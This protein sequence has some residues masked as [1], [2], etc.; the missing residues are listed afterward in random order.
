M[1]KKFSIKQFT[2]KRP[3]SWS[4]LSQWEYSKEDW[5][6]KYI[7]EEK[8]KENPEMVFGKRLAK[9]IEDGKPLAPVTMLPAREHKFEV[10]FNGIKLIGF[11]DGFDPLEKRKLA[12][13][14]SGF[15]EWNQKRVDEHGQLDFYLLCNY[16]TS[17][18]R[19]EEVDCFL[20]WIPTVKIPQENGDFKGD[21]YRI[22]FKQPI[23][24]HRFDTKRSMSDI[25]KFGARIN[26]AVKEME[27]YVQI[28]DY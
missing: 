23:E 2:K 10:V 19:P 4:S 27:R 7:L 16:I 6:K 3:L 1:S 13:Y 18:I 14:K 24:V 12:E 17:K 26:E 5:Y 11:A 28:Y 22:E 25:L 15:K 21:D 8:P 20:E 9:S